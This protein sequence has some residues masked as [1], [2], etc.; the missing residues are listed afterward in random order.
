MKASYGGIF[1]LSCIGMGLG[2]WFGGWI[3]DSAQTYALMY[4]LG[5]LG[6]AI[7]AVLAT[8]L[9]APQADGAPLSRPQPLQVF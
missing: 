7:R 4:S 2:A 8:Q 6:S 5:F 1:M 3:F 9:R